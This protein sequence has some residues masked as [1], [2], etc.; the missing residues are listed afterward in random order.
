MIEKG[1]LEYYKAIEILKFCLVSLQ[2]DKTEITK[3]SFSI[4]IGYSRLDDTSYERIIRI[5]TS[6]LFGELLK[7]VVNY[8]QYDFLINKNSLS[9]KLDSIIRELDSEK[10]NVYY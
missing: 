10:N 6:G 2:L 9:V 7:Q 4:L 8:N 3:L 5:Y 1:L